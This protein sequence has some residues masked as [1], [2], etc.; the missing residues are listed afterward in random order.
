MGAMI[1]SRILLPMLFVRC[2]ASPQAYQQERL[3]L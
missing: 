3:A 1:I 2:G